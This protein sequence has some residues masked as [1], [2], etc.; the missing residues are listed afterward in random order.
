MLRASESCF[1]IKTIGEVAHLAD[2]ALACGTPLLFNLHIAGQQSLD[3]FRQIRR[4]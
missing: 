1:L 2:S 3:G 4:D